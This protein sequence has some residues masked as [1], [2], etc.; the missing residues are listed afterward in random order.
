MT[1]KVTL[2][3]MKI[4]TLTLFG[5]LLSRSYVCNCLRLVQ[6]QMP[7]MFWHRP[8]TCKKFGFLLDIWFLGKRKKGRQLSLFLGQSKQGGSGEWAECKK[9]MVWDVCKKHSG[10]SNS[11]PSLFPSS[12]NSTSK[13]KS[14]SN[15]QGKKRTFLWQKTSE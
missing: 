2:F 13:G 3:V 6:V 1:F 7:G 10:L 15:S 5:Q 14:R 11:I 4:L 12:H 8:K 9:V